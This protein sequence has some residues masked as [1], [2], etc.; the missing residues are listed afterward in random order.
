M[1]TGISFG[2]AKYYDTPIVLDRAICAWDSAA[3]VFSA[4]Y[5]GLKATIFWRLT[6]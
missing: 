6:K 1:I 4:V 3:L 2:F 5:L